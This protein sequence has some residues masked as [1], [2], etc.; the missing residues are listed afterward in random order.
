MFFE[1][2]ESHMLEPRM[3]LLYES[4]YENTY[5]GGMKEDIWKNGQS[6]LPTPPCSPE[7]LSYQGFPEFVQTPTLA[8]SNF[9]VVPDDLPDE[10]VDNDDTLPVLEISDDEMQKLTSPTIFDDSMWIQMHSAQTHQQNPESTAQPT[11]QRQVHACEIQYDSRS[12]VSY[13]SH[14][15]RTVH[16]SDQIVRSPAYSQSFIF[17]VNAN[18]IQPLNTMGHLVTREHSTAPTPSTFNSDSNYSTERMSLLSPFDLTSGPSTP[19][20]PTTRTRKFRRALSR[21]ALENMAVEEPT[22]DSEDSETT[23][24]THNVLERK[25]REELKEK[26]QKLRDSLP[27]LQDNDRAPKV[28]ILK[29]SWVVKAH[30]FL[31]AHETYHKSVDGLKTFHI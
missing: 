1:R 18:P 11:T 16:I 20:S 23:R 2:P 9:Q 14:G 21:G 25:R 8:Q 10:L 24:A 29:K 3:S 6:L 5:E 22:D 19:D 13:I 30:C 4:S 7:E 17:T 15:I 26:F 28:L 27:E 12:D 31:E